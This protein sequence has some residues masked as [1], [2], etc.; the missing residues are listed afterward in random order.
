MRR[1]L[2]RTP[3]LFCR[4]LNTYGVTETRVCKIQGQNEATD[5]RARASSGRQRCGQSVRS[6]SCAVSA[7]CCQSV[8]RMP[9]QICLY[10]LQLEWT[11][12]GRHELHK[13]TLYRGCS[14]ATDCGVSRLQCSAS[15]A[16]LTTPPKLQK[17]L[18]QAIP[19]DLHSQRQ[20]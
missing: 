20:K 15:S 14:T 6:W 19:Q 17:H 5:E 11:A 10:H 4:L 18:L 12:G 13:S 9:P 16:P 3:N 2:S 1:W 8:Q 7:V